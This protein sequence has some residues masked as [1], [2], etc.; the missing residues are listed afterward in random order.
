MEDLGVAA[1]SAQPDLVVF[2]V[3]GVVVRSGT[4]PLPSASL[5][6]FLCRLPLWRHRSP[7]GAARPSILAPSTRL[8][9]TSGPRVY[10]GGAEGSAG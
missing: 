4:P 2:V 5:S 10:V 3:V 1:A 9:A 8:R 6:G 7:G